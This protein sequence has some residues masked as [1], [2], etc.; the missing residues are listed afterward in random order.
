MS[1]PLTDV[2]G[3]GPAAAEVLKNGGFACAEDLAAAS[4]EAVA[5]VKTFGP[6]RARAVI[7]AARELVAAPTHGVASVARE[8]RKVK[9]EKK[10]KGG[11]GRK[12]DKRKDDKKGKGKGRK[13]DKKKSK[14]NKK[15]KNR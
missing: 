6:V 9:K 4:M 10:N 11:K 1:P 3:I 7:A 5:G 12:K 2:R 13:K 14:K 15:R 8:E